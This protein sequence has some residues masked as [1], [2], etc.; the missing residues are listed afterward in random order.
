MAAAVMEC[1]V[2]RTGRRLAGCN[3]TGSFLLLLLS[4][5]IAGDASVYET[6]QFVK[7]EYS[8]IKPYQGLGS[9]SSSHWDLLGGAL[10]TPDHVRLTP[11]IQSRQ[12]AVWS[13]VPCYLRDWELQVQ[14]KVHGSGKKNFH[15]DGLAFWLTKERMQAGSVFGNMDL[16][17]GLGVFVD[18]YANSDNNREQDGRPTEIG[19]C[20]AAIRNV[21][22]DAFLLIRYT[23]NRLTIMKDVDG[24]REWR[25]C[26]EVTGLRLPLGY[27]FG[28]S[29]ATG[30][31]SDN[32]DLISMK[33]FDL[34]EMLE[35]EEEAGLSGLQFLLAAGVCL[36]GVGALGVV[37]LLIFGRWQEKSRK[38]FY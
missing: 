15:G 32:H 34:A 30:D 38:R 6:E 20:M 10:V 22:H 19:G 8:L 37:G 18:T 21:D 26:A 28:A 7:R 13:R 9:S 33:L 3:W 36:L 5:A 31:L 24:L 27:Y 17:T 14:F 23:R 1:K 4:S 11:D 2:F 16:F 35:V 12:G 25:D 29:S